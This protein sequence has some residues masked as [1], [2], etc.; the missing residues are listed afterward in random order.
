[1]G[2]RP[3][4]KGPQATATVSKHPGITRLPK[5]LT[6]PRGTTRSIHLPRTAPNAPKGS[7]SV[8]L[9]PR[10]LQSFWMISRAA[11]LANGARRP[12]RARLETALQV[13]TGVRARSRRR[14]HRSLPSCS[15]ARARWS[16]SGRRA[17][18]VCAAR[19]RRSSGTD[20]LGH[21]SPG[22]PDLRRHLQRRVRGARR[23][24]AAGPLP[25]RGAV[26]GA[27]APERR[28]RVREL[29]RAVPAARRAADRQG[30][31]EHPRPAACPEGAA[32]RVPQRLAGEEA[33]RAQRPVLPGQPH[34]LAHRRLVAREGGWGPAA[35]IQGLSPSTA[36]ALP[37]GGGPSSRR[38]TNWRPRSPRAGTAA[39]YGSSR[40]TCFRAATR[41][42]FTAARAVQP[43]WPP[44][45]SWR[46]PR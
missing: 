19:S 20:R 1:M 26:G 27:G 37:R 41:R 43:R 12:L 28:S 21:R 40:P 14:C 24:G 10:I 34:G 8:N 31:A 16:P 9:A 36:I 46:P 35:P 4:L 23:P 5:T 18:R 32:D 25:S 22:G 39:R 6:A 44:R 15:S 30:T 3:S 29:G 33:G 11:S 13:S 2:L 38:S 42:L 45:A 7:R 17:S